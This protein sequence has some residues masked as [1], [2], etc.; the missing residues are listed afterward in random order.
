LVGEL[1]LTVA[2]KLV[3]QVGSVFETVTDVTLDLS[4]LRFMDSSGIHA[5][6][7][8]ARKRNGEGRLVLKSPRGAVA[9]VLRVAGIERVEGLRIEN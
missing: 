5:L 2:P 7:Q 8:I 3:E 9:M 4:E 6:I 1:D